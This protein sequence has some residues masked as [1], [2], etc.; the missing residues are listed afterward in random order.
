KRERIQ[1][2]IA[3]IKAAINLYGVCKPEKLIEIFND[4]NDNKLT[5]EE[6]MEIYWVQADE[7]RIYRLDRGYLIG[8]YFDY[9]TEEEFEELLERTK[10]KPYY[11]PEKTELMRYSDSGYYEKIPQLSKLKAFVLQNLCKDERLVEYL[12]DD[13]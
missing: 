1:L 5:E 7:E 13:I 3:Y 8:D 6:F 2:V 12:V 11:V 4:Q 9:S 10:N